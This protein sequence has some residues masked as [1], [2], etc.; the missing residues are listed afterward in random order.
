[1]NKE[2]WAAYQRQYRLKMLRETS[3]MAD[4]DGERWTDKDDKIV[5]DTTLTIKERAF[6]LGRTNH[7][8]LDRINV[9]RTRMNN[10]D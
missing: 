9:L 3:E 6:K 5:L 8:V 7:G 2:Q 1:M 10:R 4:R